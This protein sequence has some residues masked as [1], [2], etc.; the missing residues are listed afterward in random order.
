M[1]KAEEDLEA[2]IVAEVAT[3]ANVVRVVAEETVGMATQSS[4]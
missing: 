2:M 4:I 3:R 1:D